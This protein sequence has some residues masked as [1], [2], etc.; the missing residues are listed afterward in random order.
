M[1]RRT[2]LGSIAIGIQGSIAGC[3]R[4]L[5]SGQPESSPDTQ[6]TTTRTRSATQS[7]TT[8]PKTQTEQ[9]KMIDSEIKT[10]QAEC[11]G[12]DQEDS[13]T[14]SIEEETVSIEGVMI[15]PT[16]C[17]EASIR[18]VKISNSELLVEINSDE[19]EGACTQCIGAVSYRCTITV[20]STDGISTVTVKHGEGDDEYTHTHQK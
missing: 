7:S 18:S 14:V 5:D 17:Y 11:K 13:I 1:R 12:G 6:E 10:T 19:L 9:S 8:S 16:P 15:T 4:S 2:I 3:L 20:N